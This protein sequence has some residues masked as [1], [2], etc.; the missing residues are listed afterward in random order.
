LSA[1]NERNDAPTSI[2][3]TTTTRVT[4]TTASFSGSI[5]ENP[6]EFMYINYSLRATGLN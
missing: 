5:V 6:Q 3:T 2:P 4:P 1:G